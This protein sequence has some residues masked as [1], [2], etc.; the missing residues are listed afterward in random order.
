VK[1]PISG[2]AEQMPPQPVSDTWSFAVII[3][4]IVGLGI[5]YFIAKDYMTASTG[6]KRR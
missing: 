5:G 6:R 2:E 4:L 1:T 3:V